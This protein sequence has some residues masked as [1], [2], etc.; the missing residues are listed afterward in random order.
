MHIH[1]AYIEHAI[2]NDIVIP[3]S[4][5]TSQPVTNVYNVVCH[6]KNDGM[7]INSDEQ[8]LERTLETPSS[9]FHR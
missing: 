3:Q 9:S 6:L 2:F 8:L 4:S 1:D 5:R 7:L